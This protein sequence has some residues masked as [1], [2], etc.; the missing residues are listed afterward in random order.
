MWEYLQFEQR[1]LAPSQKIEGKAWMSTSNNTVYEAEAQVDVNLFWNTSV[2]D[3]DCKWN[4]MCD[5]LHM[6]EKTFQS[7]EE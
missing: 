4:Q 5:N 3:P 7:R 2:K 1:D 6:K